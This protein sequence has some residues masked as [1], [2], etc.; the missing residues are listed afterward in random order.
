MQQ[1]ET[2]TNLHAELRDALWCRALQISAPLNVELWV[3]TVDIVSCSGQNVP[4]PSG[5]EETIPISTR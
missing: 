3:V 5:T 1:W 4:T 2:R